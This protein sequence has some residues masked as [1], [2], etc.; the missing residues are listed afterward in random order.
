MTMPLPAWNLDGPLLL[1][2]CGKMGGAMLAGWLAAGLNPADVLI[3]E[4]NPSPDLANFCAE[5]GVSLA[6]T[7]SLARAPAVI[8]MAVKPQ[9]MADV[10][11]PM[12]ARAAPHT[13][14]LSIAAGKTIA[15]FEQHLPANAAV[16][17]AMPNTPAAIGRGITVLCPNAHVSQIQRD[18]CE[19]LMS[20]VGETGWADDENLMDAVTAVSGS[21]PAYVFL[22]AEAMAQAGINAGLAPDLATQLARA[23]IAGSG[24]L[25]RQTPEVPAATHRQNVTS[26]GGT[27]AAALAVLMADEGLAALMDRAIAAATA[28]GKALAQ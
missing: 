12:A 16:V 6:A 2:G 11:P 1:V 28:R 14:I 23:T 8:I 13:I 26:P 5:K 21:G 9:V 15:S 25:M 20:A 3:Q 17:R 4:P 7:Q 24:E 22:L 18:L 10:F 19:R 27:T